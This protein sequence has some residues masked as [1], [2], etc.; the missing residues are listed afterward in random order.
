LKPKN[1]ITEQTWIPLGVAI[2]AIGGG[3]FWAATV[4][5][6]LS[7][8]QDD[9]GVIKS[10]VTQLLV[11]VNQIKTRM[12]IGSQ[13]GAGREESDEAGGAI[14]TGGSPGSPAVYRY[15]GETPDADTSDGWLQELSATIRT[16]GT[17]TIE[18]REDSDLR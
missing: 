7:Y 15:D 12:E 10:R 6:Q 11:D 8:Q 9:L 18:T 2:L 1:R 5:M 17:G 3:G 13:D 4:N 14:Q 16:L